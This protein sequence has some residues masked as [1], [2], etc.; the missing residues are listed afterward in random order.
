MLWIWIRTSSLFRK[1][2]HEK[3]K[4][5][6]ARRQR[7]RIRFSQLLKAK[8]EPKCFNARKH[9]KHPKWQMER[10]Q[11]ALPDKITILIFVSFTFSCDFCQKDKITILNFFKSNLFVHLLQGSSDFFR[12]LNQKQK[13]VLC[14]WISKPEN[15][16]LCT[17]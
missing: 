5:I 15:T 16:W 3:V 17:F 13:K 7:I 2:S 9:K 4:H 1:L 11:N 8:P 6:G 14:T 10:G 12:H